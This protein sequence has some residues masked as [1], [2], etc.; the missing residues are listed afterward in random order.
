MAGS[1]GGEKAHKKRGQSWA[2]LFSSLHVCWVGPPS[3]R[4][5][6]F[7]F[8][9]QIKSS[10]NT[11]LLLQIFAAVRQNQGNH[12]LPNKMKQSIKTNKQKNTLNIYILIKY[13]VISLHTWK[14]TYIL[15][16][17][18]QQVKEKNNLGLLSDWHLN[19]LPYWEHVFTPPFHQIKKKLI[20]SMKV[21]WDL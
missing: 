3:C 14:E 13:N 12:T 17:S 19:H 11:D 2:A 20:S 18:F 21:L 5:D 16:L 6:V 1:E 15:Q 8:A 4:E 7:S 9:C 10:C